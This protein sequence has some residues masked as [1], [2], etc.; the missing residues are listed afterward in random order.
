MR[1]LLKAGALSLA[2]LLAVPATA[3]ATERRVLAESDL[4][5]ALARRLQGERDSRETIKRLLARAE[6]RALAGESGLDLRRA[7]SA[8]DTLEGDE[9]DRLAGQAA[10]ADMALAGGDDLHISLVVL[11]LIII[12]VILLVK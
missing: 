12:I 10:S 6:V 8:V 11:L 1:H 2:V 7:A 3:R 9:L 5:R 4:D